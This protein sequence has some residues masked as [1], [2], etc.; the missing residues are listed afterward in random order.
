MVTW[1]STTW[2]NKNPQTSMVYGGE[3]PRMMK[4]IGNPTIS[5]YTVNI[6]NNKFA[7][8]QAKRKVKAEW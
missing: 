7:E 8:C 5:T 3:F 1:K 4:I 2:N 6:K